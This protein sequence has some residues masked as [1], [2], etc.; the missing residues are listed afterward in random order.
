MLILALKIKQK[1]MLS[2]YKIQKLDEV[3]IALNPDANLVGDENPQEQPPHIRSAYLLILEEKGIEIDGKEAA[4]VDVNKPFVDNWTA[5]SVVK[6][7]NELWDIDEFIQL[8][9]NEIN[10]KNGV[11]DF[12]DRDKFYK[13]VMALPDDSKFNKHSIFYDEDKESEYDSPP[14][15]D[16]TEYVPYLSFSVATNILKILKLI[17]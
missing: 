13:W 5:N 12:V 15:K 8:F 14:S 11:S 1:K 7:F 16:K 9:V 17:T 3:V 2:Q 6:K 10:Q 4:T